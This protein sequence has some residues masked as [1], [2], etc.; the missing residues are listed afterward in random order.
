MELAF[1]ADPSKSNKIGVCGAKK[2]LDDML[3]PEEQYWRQKANVKW[4]KESD[5]NTKLF[6]HSVSHRRQ[7]LFILYTSDQ[8]QPRTAAS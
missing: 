6:H 1:D 7:K 8:R 5:L 3:Q 4:V 2:E